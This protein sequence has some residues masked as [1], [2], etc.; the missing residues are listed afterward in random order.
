M[1]LDITQMDHLVF[2]RTIA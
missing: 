1:L 2:S